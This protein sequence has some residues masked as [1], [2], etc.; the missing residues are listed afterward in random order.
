MPAGFQIDNL[1]KIP[2]NDKPC[3]GRISLTFR[4]FKNE[5]I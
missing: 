4:K 1:H 3:G 5:T 2:K